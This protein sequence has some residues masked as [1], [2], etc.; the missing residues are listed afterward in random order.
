M[1]PFT[2]SKGLEFGR[3]TIL[4][5]IGIQKYDE[6]QLHAVMQ[7]I[8]T[9][10]GLEIHALESGFT[11]GINLGSPNFKNLTMPKTITIVGPG[12]RGYDAGEI[13]HLLDRR[14]GM[15]VTQMTVNRFNTTDISRYNTLILADGTYTS[16]DIAKLKSWIQQGGTVI[17]MKRAAKWLSDGRIGHVGYKKNEKDTTRK[18][19]PYNQMSRYRAAQ[20]VSGAVFRAQLDLTHPIG[21]G[22]ERPALSIFRTGALFME[23]SKSPYSTPLIYGENPLQSGYI[24]S[25]N[26]SRLKNTPAIC[27]ST[28]GRGR[29]ISFTGQSQLQGVLVRHQQIVPEQCFFRGHYRPRI[30]QIALYVRFYNG[31]RTQNRKSRIALKILFS[32]GETFVFLEKICNFVPI[33]LLVF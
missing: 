5:P 33:S 18:T 32:C 22:Y 21:F 25:K 26:L 20:L 15:P 29:V 14:V 28:I 16:V 24:S 11:G 8:A 19:L 4:I 13:W 1:E 31:F 12:I 9:D 23:P 3:G 10:C 17:A 6:D 27:I 30:R 7:D 2:S